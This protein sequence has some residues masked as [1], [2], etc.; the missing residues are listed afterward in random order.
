MN[1]KLKWNWR[2]LA[3]CAAVTLVG[4]SAGGV[5]R[6]QTAPADLSPDVQE[7]LTLSRQHMDDSVITNYIISSGKS[8]KLSADD[9]LYLNKQGVSEPVINVLLQTG[10]SGGDNAQ[11]PAPTPPA[12]IV[13]TPTEPAPPLQ[14]TVVSV[15]DSAAPALAPTPAPTLSGTPEPTMGYY[16]AQ[17]APYGTWV[18]APGHGLCWQPAVAA[19]W[20]P[21]YDGGRWVYTDAGWYWQS[22][23]PWGDIAFHYGR[24]IYTSIGW[25]WVPGY[26][27]APAW[28]VWRHDDSDS[29]IGW[30]PLPPGAVFV[31]SGWMFNGNHVGVDFGFG[32]DASYFTFV[33]YDHFW[34][35]NF[36]AFVVPHDRMV[37]A[38]WHSNV[39]NRYAF[40][41]G[42]F[43]NE[44]LPHER[45]IVLTHREIHPVPVTDVRREEEAHNVQLRRDDIHNF[46][47]GMAPDARDGWKQ[48]PNNGYNGGHQNSEHDQGHNDQGHNG[49]GH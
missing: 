34:D 9:I 4:I 49:G 42:R 26:E 37:Y 22:D 16:Q 33:G 2:N 39:A 44:G 3:A 20:R 12:P 30:A 13:A 5:C 48:A 32:L 40:E 24:W 31:N 35:H 10:S 27:Y 15:P 41:H 25:A 23:Y 38:Y 6:A 45:M 28:V 46:H 36:R 29:Y 43:V 21:Y 7:V 14:G 8:Y 11:T 19:G 47:P 1:G 17:L 18:D